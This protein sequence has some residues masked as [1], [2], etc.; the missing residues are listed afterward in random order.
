MMAVWEPSAAD[1]AKPDGPYG[2]IAFHLVEVP[3]AASVF[4]QVYPIWRFQGNAVT[5][6]WAREA[7][8]LD[9]DTVRTRFIMSTELDPTAPRIAQKTLRD[10][11]Y[12]GALA[13]VPDGEF[14]IVAH[15]GR[16]RLAKPK[17][18][19]EDAFVCDIPAATQPTAAAEQDIVIAY[20][21][22]CLPGIKP[23]GSAGACVPNMQALSA[24]V[25]AKITDFA[26]DCY[27]L[28]QQ[29]QIPLAPSVLLHN[30]AV[31]GAPAQHAIPPILND[32]AIFASAPASGVDPLGTEWV[33]VFQVEHLPPSEAMR[34]RL[35][36]PGKVRVESGS[37]AFVG[38]VL[39]WPPPA[40]IDG[41]TAMRYDI[42]KGPIHP[43]ETMGAQQGYASLLTSNTE[44]VWYDVDTWDSFLTA[45]PRTA[46]DEHAFFSWLC[47]EM[48]SSVNESFSEL[49]RLRERLAKWATRA[50][51]MESWRAD[52]D[53]AT[54]G[55][56]TAHLMHR[57][58][59]EKEH[60][61]SMSSSVRVTAKELQKAV[62]EK[63]RKQPVTFTSAA[64]PRA[65]NTRQRSMYAGMDVPIKG[66]CNKCG[67]VGHKAA[68]CTQAGSIQ[69]PH[70]PPPQLSF[71]RN[72]APQ[73][74]YGRGAQQG[75]RQGGA[76]VQN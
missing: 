6:K 1:P 10:I 27:A 24:E 52:L 71:F 76:S 65:A 34:L 66:K 19:R 68:F 53:F 42:K 2:R 15:K 57:L 33:V 22:I 67:L 40:T 54:E 74:S 29:A 32:Y 59:A 73:P 25:I 64:Q 70:V 9:A 46:I 62:N 11:L 3:A 23:D 28:S 47:R 39:A 37:P 13:Q 49:S 55:R 61:I 58:W 48:R 51:K 45:G 31:P 44:P 14:V 30:R 56:E 17:K 8:T 16:P 35:V 20:G 50:S 21:D 38:R 26:K 7:G 41:T 60:G 18:L 63:L 43:H 12:R 4:Q 5:G 75:F 72:A 69:P 36:E